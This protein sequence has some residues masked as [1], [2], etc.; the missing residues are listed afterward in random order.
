MRLPDIL[1]P[2]SDTQTSKMYQ[3]TRIKM[4]FCLLPL[5][6]SKLSRLLRNMEKTSFIWGS[7]H[8]TILSAK[9]TI[10]TYCNRTRK[11]RE[12]S[13]ESSTTNS[14]TKKCTKENNVEKLQSFTAILAACM[15]QQANMTNGLNNIWR[16]LLTCGK[17][18]RIKSSRQQSG[19][20]SACC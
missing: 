14:S 18:W 19:T 9:F 17:N 6:N 3:P 10:L 2:F 12:N 8:P 13:K 5:Q 1:S 7:C 15:S 20:I 16:R 11:L 4:K